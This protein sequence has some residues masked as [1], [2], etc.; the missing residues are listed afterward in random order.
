MKSLITILILVVIVIGGLFAWKHNSNVSKS[1][2]SPTTQDNRFRTY[3]NTT[4]DFSIEVP[5]QI[6]AFNGKEEP[7]EIKESGNITFLTY[8]DSYYASKIET[9]LKSTKTDIEKSQGI[10]WAILVVD[11]NNDTELDAF[12][13]NRYG[14]ECALGSK[15]PT[16]QSGTYDVL[17]G[18]N[19][20][21]E[22]CF[23]NYMT[24]IKYSP[25]KHKVVV[26]DM[27]QSFNF[28]LDENTPAD[29]IMRQSFR[30]L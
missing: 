25:T 26:W 22:H 21:P 4:H 3:T 10:P 17:I 11:I 14:S 29:E 18:G 7:L 15:N 27:G 8:A 2:P 19:I 1:T 12:I 28:L 9:V 20:S 23:V 6:R 16:A 5:I 24:V 13:K 30:F